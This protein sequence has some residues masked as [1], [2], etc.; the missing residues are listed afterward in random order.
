[1]RG[2]IPQAAGLGASWDGEGGDGPQSAA[3]P[4]RDAALV[5]LPGN[6][7]GKGGVA[8]GWQRGADG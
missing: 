5:G 7:A 3:G 6:A 8:A 4:T 2:A 1:M